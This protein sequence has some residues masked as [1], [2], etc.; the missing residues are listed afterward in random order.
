MPSHSALLEL[1]SVFGQLLQDCLRSI[2]TQNNYRLRYL[3]PILYESEIYRVN[4][5]LRK[6]YT[7]VWFS[8][9]ASQM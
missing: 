7:E 4:S 8:K 2:V 1:Y 6:T 5:A 9:V 3:L